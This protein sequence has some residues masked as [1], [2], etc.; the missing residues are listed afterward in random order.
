MSGT[1]V[2][3]AA[4]VRVSGVVQG[5]GFRPFVHR[6]AL[7]HGLG[8]WVRNAAG[9]VQILVEGPP[10]ALAAFE[11]DLRG[12]APPLARIER[13][14]SEPCPPTGLERFAIAESRDEPGR[15]QPISPDVAMCA[16][17]EAELTDPANRRYGYP[18]ITCTDCGPRFTVIDA[19][20]YDRERTSMRAFTQNS[21]VFSCARAF[22]R[23][24]APSARS[25]APLYAPPRWFPCPPP[26]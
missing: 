13:L 17:C 4:R 23:K 26:P 22:E 10:Q 2:R 12:N 20:P 24:R 15:R 14:D 6:L 8:G 19:M 18:F 9:D 5:V 21:P 16:A 3:A 7:R 11:R 25:V 1:T